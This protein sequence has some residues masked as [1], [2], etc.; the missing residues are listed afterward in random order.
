MTSPKVYR[1][2]GELRAVANTLPAIVERTGA[3]GRFAWDEF[4]SGHLRNRHTRAAYLHAVKRFLAWVEPREPELARITPG[5][6]GWYFDEQKLAIPSKKLHLSALRRFFDLL[7]QR[8]VIVLNPA[9]SVRTERYQN[10]E[11]KTPEISTE[12]ARK[13][14]QSIELRLIGDYRDK[15]VIAALI[16]TAARAGAIARLR[17]KDFVDEGGAYSLQFH[18]KGGKQR[19][20]PVR[21]DLQELLLQYLDLADPQRTDKDAPLFR[22]LGR[23]NRLTNNPLSGIDICRMVKRLYGDN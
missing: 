10:I 21:H 22:T 16:F 5:L 8:H 9:L 2:G 20:I 14:L 7:V 6:M 12:Q 17:V 1:R 4:F 18:E 15:A 19:S 11:G 23:G 3:A 13:L